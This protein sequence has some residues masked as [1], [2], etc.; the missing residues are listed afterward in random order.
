[1]YSSTDVSIVI[2]IN[3]SKTMNKNWG[4]GKEEEKVDRCGCEGIVLAYCIVF[5]RTAPPSSNGLGVSSPTP[6][7]SINKSDQ[8]NI[9]LY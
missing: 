6:L 8:D 9:L 3:N 7:H 4:K 1:M 2:K 5:G